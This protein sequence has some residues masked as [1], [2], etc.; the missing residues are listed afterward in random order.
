[1]IWVRQT[2]KIGKI[3]IYGSQVRK[4]VL[5]LD[6]RPAAFSSTAQ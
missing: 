3:G 1:M 2:K 5:S 6:L 4:V